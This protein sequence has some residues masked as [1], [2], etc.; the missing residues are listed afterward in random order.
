MQ[1]PL[2]T[3]FIGGI[4]SSTLLTLAV[5]PA[6]YRLTH[7]HW[8]PQGRLASAR[9]RAGLP[10]REITNSLDEFTTRG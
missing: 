6:L 7:Q 3:V 5:L 8:M 4:V 10:E 1:R 9:S 2:A